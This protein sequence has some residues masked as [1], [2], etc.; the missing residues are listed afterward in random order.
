MN[1]SKYNLEQQ[2]KK[3]IEKREI[4]PTRDLWAEIEI[5][6]ANNIPS[7]SN[8]KWFLVAAIFLLIAGLSVILFFN[9]DQYIEPQIVKI[10]IESQKNTVEN[11]SS[12]EIS[13]I[14]SEKTENLDLRNTP[15]VSS[16]KTEKQ[17]ATLALEKGQSPLKIEKK[18]PFVSQTAENIISNSNILA[19]TDSI[20]IPKKRKKYVDASTL[21]FSVEHKDVIEKSKDGSNV[22][23]IDLN[24]K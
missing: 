16:E 6:K 4:N 2:V 13:P 15:L 23:T 8:F 10:H 21:L 14:K 3:Q 5:Q 1:D 24:S 18:E 22:A 19:A 17:Q 12:K 9:N 11:R 7:K 20:N